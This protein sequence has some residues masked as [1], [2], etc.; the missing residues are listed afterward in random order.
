MRQ[1]ANLAF[2]KNL[3][4]FYLLLIPIIVSCANQPQKPTINWSPFTWS[5]QNVGG[6]MHDKTAMLLPVKFEGDTSTY[7]MQLDMGVTATVL[8]GRSLENVN[9][10]QS[11]TLSAGYSN[12]YLLKTHLTLDNQT[13]KTDTF[14]VMRNFRRSNPRLVGS[15]GIKELKRKILLIDYPNNRFALLDSFP[16]N[17][18][19]KFESISYEMD[20]Q[21]RVG[22][23]VQVGDSTYN[24]LFDTSSSL[25]AMLTINRLYDKFT[26]QTKSGQDTIIASSWGNTLTLIGARNQFP[27][28]VGHIALANGKRVYKT[29]S[30]DFMAFFMEEGVD[31]IISNP[32]FF[33]DEIMI[34]FNNH[35]F[36]IRTNR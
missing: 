9:I 16:K 5:S 24:F 10:D 28:K 30:G 1:K 34:N 8:Y 18:D 3:K 31:G 23:P 26:G 29:N 20:R 7:Q 35:Q 36:G 27:V 12:Y 13:L 4:R 14:P 19:K 32:Y 11:D 25:T 17:Y 22:L 33:D 6:K 21:G 15:I 2:M